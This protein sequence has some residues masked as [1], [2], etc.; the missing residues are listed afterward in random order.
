MRPEKFLTKI[1]A[2]YVKAR[3]PVLPSKHIKRG[4]SRSISS[5][6]EDLFASYLESMIPRDYEIWIDPQITINN[7]KNKSGKRSL[8]FRPD[9]CIINCKTNRIEM[10]FDIKMDLGYKRNNF[11]SQ[12]KV[13]IGELNNIVK[14]TARCSL[15]DDELKFS[16]KLKWNYVVMSAGNITPEQY[17]KVETWFT[18]TEKATLFTLSRGEHLNTYSDNFELR[19]NSDDFKR[20]DAA[21]DTLSTIKRKSK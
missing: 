7:L 8:L 12:V 17:D 1:R 15:K 16:N 11:I 19:V 21:I 3:N 2:A 9:I 4:T 18:N 10:I 14:H 20:I 13:R 6:A 5:V